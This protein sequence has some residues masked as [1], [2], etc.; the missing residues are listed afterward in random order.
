M[1]KKET[2]K[3]KTTPKKKA[4]AKKEELVVIAQSELEAVPTVE[5]AEKALEI[6]NGDP[7]V[8]APVEEEAPVEVEEAAPVEEIKAEEPA[9]EEPTPEAK[10]TVHHTENKPKRNIVSRVFGYLWNGQEM[11]I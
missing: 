11:D 7:A 8:V 6:M 5:D 4:V 10:K 9:E 1:A 3:K 2:T